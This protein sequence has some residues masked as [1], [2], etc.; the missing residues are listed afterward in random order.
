LPFLVQTPAAYVAITESD[1]LDWSAMWLVPKVGAKYTLELQLA[2]PIPARP[3][4]ELINDQPC[5]G[6]A[7]RGADRRGSAGLVVAKTPHNSPGARF[8]H[9]PPAAV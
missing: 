5:G 9:R 1:L 2:P 6:G 7:I 3:C 8:P 4:A